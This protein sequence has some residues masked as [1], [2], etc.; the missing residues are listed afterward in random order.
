MRKLIEAVRAAHTAE[1]PV[2]PGSE[3][4]KWIEW[5]HQQ[6]DRLDPLCPSPP[7]I[8]DEEGLEEEEPRR[9]GY[10]W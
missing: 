2:E 8:L 10:R 6:A 3:L 5:A 9:Y 1:G 7:S 4:A